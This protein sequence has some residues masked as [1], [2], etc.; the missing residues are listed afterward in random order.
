MYRDA[1]ALEDELLA[2]DENSWN[3]WPF[4]AADGTTAALLSL[5]SD[6]KVNLVPRFMSGASCF[7]R[8]NSK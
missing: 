1:V 2:N 4:L 8:S 6:G 3:E 5:V 7:S